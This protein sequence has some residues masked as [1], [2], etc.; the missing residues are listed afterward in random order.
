M[1]T[2]W[3][4]IRVRTTL[5]GVHRRRGERCE[6]RTIMRLSLV[7]IFIVE[8]PYVPYNAVDVYINAVV[9]RNFVQ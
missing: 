6:N 9:G 8:S 7:S 3:P 1:D 2:R 5:P 4:R